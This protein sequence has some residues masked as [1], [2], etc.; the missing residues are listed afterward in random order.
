MIVKEP[1]M[2]DLQDH[3]RFLKADL[4]REFDRMESDQRRGIPAPPV[5][6]PAPAGA[7]RVDLPPPERFTVGQ[8]PVIEAIRRRRTRR[9]FTADPLTLEELAFLL[10]ATQGAS[11]DAA[12]DL[13]RR[14]EGLLRTVPSGGARHPF[15]T[16]LVIRRVTGLAEGLYRYLPTTHQLAFLRPYAEIAGLAAAAWGQ[17]RMM[18]DAAVVFVW[19]ALPYRSEWRYA[20]VAAKLIA[21]DSG[22]VCQNLYLACEVIG[23]GTCAV[24]AYDQ[25]GA[26]AVVGVD[27]EE[28][29]AIY[30]APV[31]KYPETLMG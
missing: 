28:E 21:Q 17:R 15:E 6:K 13:L 23:A 2:P 19:T 16:Y 8:M 24:G 26:D 5:E 3:R 14:G 11:R 4:W 25:R 1:P 22:H 30:L 12:G 7:A 31:G 18:A 20:L 9:V 10:W 29:F 27:G